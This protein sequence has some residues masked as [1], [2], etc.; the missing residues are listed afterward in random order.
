MRIVLIVFGIVFGS[1]A[2]IAVAAFGL[3]WKGGLAVAS[4]MP[5]PRTELTLKLDNS[6]APVIAVR[7]L[8]P[9]LRDGLREPRI[10]FAAIT[11]SGDAIDVTLADGVD[12]SQ[13]LA[14]LHELARPSGANADNFTVADLGGALVRLTPTPAALGAAAKGADEQTFAVL[15][16]RLE[17]LQIKAAVRGAGGDAVVA[18][19]QADAA[20]LK[21]LLVAPGKLS[22]RLV[23]ASV[24]VDA[25]KGGKMPPQSELLSGADGT[26]YLIEKRVVMPGDNLTDAQAS[27]DQRTNEPVVSFH[28]NQAG[29]RQFARVTAENVGRPMAVVLDGVVLAVPVIREA[30]T[31][32]SGQISG[33][34]NLERANDLAV[35][36]GSGALPVPVTV[37]AERAL[38][39]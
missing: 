19:P 26:P 28:F 6:V 22:L 11:A 37:V 13:A 38:E 35:M 21:A 10:G 15:N 27:F 7:D 36:L 32:G 31:G 5:Q 8:F 9:A 12:R 16:H 2:L 24:S 17:G 20:R 39:R 33:G 30:I 1:L 3:W 4:L 34:F 14:R 25:A 23:D 18:V 29:T